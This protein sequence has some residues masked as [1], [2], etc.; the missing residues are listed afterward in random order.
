MSPDALVAEVGE[1]GRTSG[2]ARRSMPRRRAPVIRHC[3]R[4]RV[5]VC[6]ATSSSLRAKA[7]RGGH[8]AQEVRHPPHEGPRRPGQRVCAAPV[9]I[10]TH[11]DV[12]ESSRA[13]ASRAAEHPPHDLG[14]GRHRR[15]R[16]GR[17]GTRR[18]ARR[19]ASRMRLRSARSAAVIF[20]GPGVTAT[21]S[22]GWRSHLGHRGRRPRGERPEPNQPPSQPSRPAP[23]SPPPRSERLGLGDPRRMASIRRRG[24]PGCGEERPPRLPIARSAARG[25]AEAFRTISATPCVAR[26][27]SRP[28]TRAITA[29]ILSAWSARVR[30]LRPGR[31]VGFQGGAARVEVHRSLRRPPL[32]AEA[33]EATSS[34]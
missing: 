29:A 15:A 25:E 8:P 27:I 31:R 2:S 13:T 1:H 14:V 12:R 20:T 11:A 26:G 34:G 30:R 32:G 33:V 9:C 10:D 7:L 28:A 19:V 16:H 3:S 17:R 21:T 4:L 6:A 18:G 5:L 24:S 22:P 23:A